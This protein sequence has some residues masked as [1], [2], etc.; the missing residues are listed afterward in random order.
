MPSARRFS[1]KPAFD[2]RLPIA[3]FSRMNEILAHA[4]TKMPDLRFKG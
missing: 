1:K 2:Q 4:F 3:I